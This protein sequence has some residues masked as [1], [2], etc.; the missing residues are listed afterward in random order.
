M[1]EDKNFFPHIK[2]WHEAKIR[3][4]VASLI[5]HM[6]P[7]IIY[8]LT[9]DKL[10]KSFPSRVL[11]LYDRLWPFKSNS[12]Y[13]IIYD[14]TDQM[15][16]LPRKMTVTDFDEWI[17]HVESV[18]RIE[19]GMRARLGIKGSRRKTIHRMIK[20]DQSRQTWGMEKMANLA[21]REENW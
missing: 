15:I 10:A 18:N 16:E 11:E 7:K 2:M 19:R 1:I 4:D 13:Q 20:A 14:A 9:H 12:N 3:H 8:I 21:A 17:V 5:K 6:E